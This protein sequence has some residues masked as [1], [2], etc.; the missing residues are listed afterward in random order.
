MYGCGSFC[1]T[2]THRLRKPLGD[3][4]I[5]DCGIMSSIWGWAVRKGIT[6]H[7]RYGT[8]C[9]CAAQRVENCSFATG[10][11]PVIKIKCSSTITGTRVSFL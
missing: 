9:K 10:T 8:I 4:R 2:D 1:V 5:K 6:R 7:N 3:Y 11:Y